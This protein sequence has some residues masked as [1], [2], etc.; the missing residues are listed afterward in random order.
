MGRPRGR[1]SEAGVG[2]GEPGRKR[3][4]AAPPTARGLAFVGGR[5]Q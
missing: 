4:P 3:A 2:C 5:D 1:R